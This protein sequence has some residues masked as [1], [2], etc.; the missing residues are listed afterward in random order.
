[1]KVQQKRFYGLSECDLHQI[2]TATKVFP[3]IEQ[4]ILFGSRAKG[5]DKTGSDVDLAIKGKAVTYDTVL[6]LSDCLNEKIPLPYFFD[7]V[8]YQGIQEPRLTTHID[9][10]GIVIFDRNKKEH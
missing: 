2:I 6:Q 5:T 4:L 9:N 8:D 7:V 3:E 1:M 10:T